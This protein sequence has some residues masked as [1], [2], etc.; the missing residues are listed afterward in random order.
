MN[1]PA[2]VPLVDKSS[3]R[4]REMFGQIAPRYDALNHL[5]SLNMDRYWRYRVV[6]RLRITNQLPIL[7]ACTGTGDLALAIQRHVQESGCSARVIGTDFCPQMLEYARQKQSKQFIEEARIGFIEADTQALP[8]ES[9]SFQSVTVAYGLRNVADTESGLRE[10]ARVC[11][12]GGQV[13]VLE[14]S[15]PQFP[16][17]KQ[18]YGF[19]FR[20]ILPRIGQCFAKND[21][22]AYAYLPESVGQ[23]PQGSELAQRMQAAGLE[24]VNW[25]SMTFG[26]TTLYEGTKPILNETT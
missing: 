18:M 22:S 10:L 21:K 9:N 23:F 2:A 17:I 7:D 14:F 8:F 13:I 20:R 24:K 4:I 15:E 6:K 16:V 26:V 5:L 1:A 19:Y 3:A 11:A 12:P 25:T